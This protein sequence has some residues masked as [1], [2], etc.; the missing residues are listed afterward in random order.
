[1]LLHNRKRLRLLGFNYSSQRYYFF[2]IVVKNHSHSFGIIKDKSV[3]LSTN[4]IIAREQWQ[5]LGSQYPYI[6]LVSF[7]VMP[8]HVHGIIYINAG[9]FIKNC[10]VN[11]RDHSQQRFQ[12]IKPLPELIGAYKTTVS[13]RIHL[14]GDLTFGWQNSYHE[15]IIRNMNELGMIKHYI[16]TNPE[17][18][19]GK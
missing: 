10:Y 13:K 1:M 14:A 7:I 9:Y 12:K 8:D 11:G 6:N 17:R 19:N 16:E 4:G 3:N 18:W 15:R 5:W 2:T